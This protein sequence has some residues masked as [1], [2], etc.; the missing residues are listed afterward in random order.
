MTN[1]ET[2]KYLKYCVGDGSI[3]FIF[4]PIKTEVLENAINALEKQIEQ[5]PLVSDIDN[6][7]NADVYC[8]ICH[9]NNPTAVKSINR[10]YCWKCGQLLS[11][12]WDEKND[13]K[14][15]SIS[16]RISN[17]NDA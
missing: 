12:D 15:N 17:Q 7:D 1:E 8:P 4:Q 13:K 16:N 3:G 6:N 14:T 9:A 10:I 2:L 11:I 5:K